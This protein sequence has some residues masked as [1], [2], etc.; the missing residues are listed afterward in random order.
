M[1]WRIGFGLII[2]S[3][4]SACQTEQQYLIPPVENAWDGQAPDVSHYKVR[5]GDTLYS[6]AWAFGLDVMNVAQ[7][8]EIHKPF[9][10]YPE[11]TIK[12]DKAA[13]PPTLLNANLSSEKQ[14]A[15]AINVKSTQESISNT[16]RF[17]SRLAHAENRTN[18][19]PKP[20]ENVVPVPGRKTEK[21]ASN[22]V[23]V[24]TT[25]KSSPKGTWQWPAAGS[26]RVISRG[27]SVGM[28]IANSLGTPIVATD[29]G[30]IVYSGE[31]IKGYGKL[32]IIKHKN[33]ILSAYAH[34][35]Q[36]LVKEGDKVAK[37]QQIATMGNTPTGDI[38]LYFE[39]RKGGVPV[40]PLRFLTKR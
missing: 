11:Q 17:K 9:K 26:H 21:N 33:N 13:S 4:L 24:P 35:Q 23:S 5:Q 38:S 37:G 3:C 20:S 15:N 30:R 14:T 10:I 18:L 12:L 6:I 27:Q 32:L 36:R 40:N 2:L 34:N 22:Q 29:A 19:P 39:I 28:E 16:S 25:L 8:N 7:A 31:G 1:R